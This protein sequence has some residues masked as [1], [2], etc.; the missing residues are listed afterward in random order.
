MKHLMALCRDAILA[1]RTQVGVPHHRNFQDLSSGRRPRHV[2][3]RMLLA[4]RPIPFTSEVHSFC[5]GTAQTPFCSRH[6]L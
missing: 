5:S 3:G 4:S 1:R 6:C 2:C